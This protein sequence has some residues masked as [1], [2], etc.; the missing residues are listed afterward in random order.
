MEIVKLVNISKTYG[1]NDAKVEALKNISL[2]INE[3]ELVAIVGSSGSG[4]STLLNIIGCIDKPTEG[5]C[6][7]DNINTKN[8]KE[9]ELAK[10]RNK[11]LGF[12]LQYF[13]L[14][15]S[16]TVYEN[17]ELPLIYSKS[18]G[19]KE[20]VVN[21]LKKLNIYDKENKLPSELSGGQNQRVAIARALVNEPKIILAD[22]PTGALDKKTSQQVMDILLG[23][24]KEGKTIIIVTHDENI[25]K[26]CHRTIRIE[27]G[28]IEEWAQIAKEK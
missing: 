7:I 22:E 18:K 25:S 6:F 28:Y 16:Y 10:C 17:V 27:D 9:R 23:L 2:T 21:I 14:I 13:G 11:L 26:Q 12:V 3:G 24:N 5:E 8:C 4:K 1:E 15:T 19:R 20:K